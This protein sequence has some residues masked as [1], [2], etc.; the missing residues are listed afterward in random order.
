M[1][2]PTPF[3]SWVRG[4]SPGLG[5]QRRRFPLWDGRTRLEKKFAED[6]GGPFSPLSFT[7]SGSVLSGGITDVWVRWRSFYSVEDNAT[8]I[9]SGL[10]SVPLTP[11][12]RPQRGTKGLSSQDCVIGTGCFEVCP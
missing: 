2:Y 1:S 9:V 10:G 5:F 7:L 12:P 6:L 4:V 3:C 11:N 8:V